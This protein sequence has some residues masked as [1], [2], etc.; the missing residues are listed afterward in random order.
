[1]ATL[2][3]IY[4]P[5]TSDATSIVTHQGRLSP[6]AI[7]YDARYRETLAKDDRRQKARRWAHQWGCRYE[8]AIVIP[9][10]K[11]FAKGAMPQ[12]LSVCIITMNSAGRI[13]PLLEYLRPHVA[14]I[15]VGVDSK[16]TDNT[17]AVCQGLADELFT[18]EN[19]SATCN[20][21]L[22][23]IVNRCHGDW[24]LRLDDDEYPEPTLWTHLQGIMAAEHYTHYKLPRLHLC[25]AE[26]LRWIDDGYLYPDYQ[27]RLFRNDPEAIHFPGAV[28]HLGITCDGPKGRLNTINLIHLNLAMNPRPQREAKL[29]SYVDRL[30]G[31]W[32]HPINERALLFE[33][34]PYH[35]RPYDAP[36]RGFTETLQSALLQIAQNRSAS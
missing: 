4:A 26:P 15:V 22:E 10:W 21:G 8:R 6:V 25:Q 18:V 3:L 14:E 33:D 1:M 34:Y 7:A 17:L 24:I 11:R 12:K 35:V 9:R 20:G 32:V 30:N 5:E 31:G 28:G 2:P 27:M 23:A 16:T 29:K 19:P 13:K 36:A